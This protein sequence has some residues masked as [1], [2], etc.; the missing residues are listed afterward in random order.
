MMAT[1]QYQISDKALT[2]LTLRRL[3]VAYEHHLPFLDPQSG[4]TG[5]THLFSRIVAVA[6]AFDALTTQ[7]TWREGYTADEALKVLLGEAGTRF[8]PLVVRTLVNVIGQYPLGAPV[9][10]ES[11][12]I[13][14]VYHNSTSAELYDR[15]W[16]RVLLDASGQRV[17]GTAI[18][19]LAEAHGPGG[20]IARLAQRSE[21]PEGIDTAILTLF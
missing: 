18:R 12:E 6:D 11:G 13:A 14:I 4:R 10:L 3:T 17:K 2:K 1:I 5:G 19:N 20:Q 15:P 21:I 16:V 7:R 9:L 8:D